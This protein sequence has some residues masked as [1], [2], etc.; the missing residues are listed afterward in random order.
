MQIAGAKLPLLKVFKAA[1]ANRGRVNSA[2]RA[3]AKHAE[4]SANPGCL[5]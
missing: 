2:I 3:A 4:Q 5:P 1:T